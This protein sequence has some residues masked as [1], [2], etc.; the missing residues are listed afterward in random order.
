MKISLRTK[1]AATL[2][3]FVALLMPVSVL[4]VDIL[5]PVC[6]DNNASSYTAP[7]DS[8]VCQEA[9]SSK[10]SNPLYGPDGVL[11]KAIN[12]LSLV[13][14]IL[15]V[16]VIILSGINF[17]TSQGEPQKV[18]NARN[19]IIYAIVGLFVA[20]LAQGIVVFVLKRL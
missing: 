4:A 10:N 1:F 17:I 14:G 8:T 13:V 9:A 11:T 3:T 12:G 20:V 5:A 19:R 18:T 7:S 6:S 15:S 16:I 2:I